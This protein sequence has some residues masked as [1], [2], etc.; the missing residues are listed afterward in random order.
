MEA[1]GRVTMPVSILANHALVDGC[2]L[3]QF[4]TALN[5]EMKM[6]TTSRLMFEIKHVIL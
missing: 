2:Y 1:K 5:K 6:F 4:Y 3:A